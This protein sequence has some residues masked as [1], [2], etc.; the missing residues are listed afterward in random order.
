MIG[1]KEYNHIY[2][3]VDMQEHI[4]DDIKCWCEPTRD[5]EYQ[6]ITHNLYKTPMEQ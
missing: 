6:V 5:E 4:L 3:A 2:P 1:N